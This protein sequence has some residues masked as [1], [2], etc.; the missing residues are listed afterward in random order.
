MNPFQKLALTLF[1]VALFAANAMAQCAGKQV[2][3]ELPSDWTKSEVYIK[4]DGMTTIPATTS[5]SWTIFTFPATSDFN[6]AGK[7]FG[8]SNNPAESGTNNWINR[9]QYNFVGQVGTRISCAA[10]TFNADGRVYIYPNPNNPSQTMVTQLPPNAYNFYFLPPDDPEWTVGIPLLVWFDGTLQKEKLDYDASRCGW[11]KKTWFN[12]TPPS[13]ITLIW[14][15]GGGAIGTPKGNPDDQLGILGFDEDPLDWDNGMPTP[16]SL[17]EQFQNITGGTGDLF[18]VPANGANGWYAT[19]PGGDGNCK[20]NF[21]AIIY[22]TDGSVNSSFLQGNTESGTGIRKNIPQ[23]VLAPDPVSGVMKMQFNTAKNGWTQQNFMDAFRPTTGKNVVRCYDMPFNRN[24]AGLWEFNSNKLCRLQNGNQDVVDLDGNCSNYGGF[25]GGFFPT[26]LQTAEGVTGLPGD[27][28][29]CSACRNTHTAESFVPLNATISEYCYDRG[30]T[31]TGTACGAEFVE[32]NFSDGEA[33]AIWN[34]G[35]T[36]PTIPN[37]NALYCFESSPAELTYEPGQQ[38][39]F[40]GDDDIW[41]Y[42][43]NQL[44]IDL[45]GSHLAAP[46]YVNLDDLVISPQAQA[47]TKDDDGAQKQFTPQGR[48][49][50]GEKYPINIFFC[51]RRLTMSNVRITTDMYFASKNTLGVSGNATGSG[52]AEI[53]LDKSGSVGTCKDVMSGGSGTI[54]GTQCGEAMG[55]IL[56]YYMQNRQGDTTGFSLDPLNPMCQKVGDNLVCY[57][58]IILENYYKNPVGSVSKIKVDY[59][60]TSGLMGTYRLYAKINDANKSSFPNEKPLFITTVRAEAVEQ[61]I[62]GKVVDDGG[63]FIFNLGPRHKKTVS[64][65]RVPVGFSTGDWDCTDD[66]RK[67]N[68]DCPFRVATWPA[69]ELGALGAQVS[70]PNVHTDPGGRESDLRWYKDSVGGAPVQKPSGGIVPANPAEAAAQG[71]SKMGL[72]IY[73]VTGE[74]EAANDQ[75]HTIGKEL[76]VEV[77]LPRLAFVDPGT[78]ARLNATQTQ[79]SEY[80]WSPG[81]TSFREADIMVGEPTIRA[82]AAYGAVGNDYKDFF[83]DRVCTSCNFDLRLN[84][85]ITIDGVRA[86]TASGAIMQPSPNP[87]KIEDGYADFNINGRMAVPGISNGH[88][89]LAFFTMGIQGSN[90]TREDILAEWNNLIFTA[91]PVPYPT[92]V[93]IYDVNGDGFGDSLHIIYNRKFPQVG[94]IRDSLPSMI[95]IAWD[96]DTVF[97]FG[98]GKKSSTDDSKWTTSGDPQAD[99][100]YWTN[101]SVGNFR[102]RMPNDST[103]AIYGDSLSKE[104]QTQV[105]TRNQITSEITN[106]ATYINPK[107]G[108][109]IPAD[110]GAK[111]GINDSIPAIVVKAIFEADKNTK[112]GSGR[113]STCKDQ[114]TITVSEPVKEIPGLG[115]V[116]PKA[117]FAYK[118]ISRGLSEFQRHDRDIHLAKSIRPNSTND[119]FFLNYERFRDG[120]D[121]TNTPMGGDSVKFVWAGLGEVVFTDMV[122]N[123]PN[124]R[125]QGRRFEGTNPFG[126]D[127][128]RIADLDP[129]KDI[130]KEAVNDVLGPTVSY[131]D[132]FKEDKQ[133]A[134]IPAED[135]WTADSIKIKF[136]G[137][138]GQFFSPD[139]ANT[140]SKM[141]NELGVKIDPSKITFH[142]KSF[143]HTNLGN[144]VVQSK[145]LVVS[146]TDKIFTAFGDANCMSNTGTPKG[147][148]LAWNLKDA[149]NRWVGAGAYVE[150]YDFYWQV[151]YDQG[152]GEKTRVIDNVEKRVEMLGVRRAK[153]K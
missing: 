74:Y 121:T 60:K 144:Y 150:V 26:E 23:N 18:F 113:T 7:S 119:V 19:D 58:G 122:G 90:A 91:P 126:V 102:M 42:I 48:L 136:P 97:R 73:W 145:E 17:M 88:D 5:G 114:V 35:A 142:A 16:F 83:P 115:N 92:S 30:R 11:F 59:S 33:P 128:I 101:G 40:S 52:G 118:L 61:Q 79:G 8:L 53:C 47:I 55:N 49:V 56:D 45:G 146:C 112:C 85:W 120:V 134:F 44:V 57:G 124:P 2:Y 96:P 14:L 133:V 152:G 138:V 139:V 75:I 69:S 132:L 93:S 131:E 140:V 98:P 129:E 10:S 103:I 100:T 34:W 111:F 43:S 13:G 28:T 94:S 153:K 25:M 64:G 12:A 84:A 95:E 81:V 135:S 21:A 32:G 4:S 116:L 54:Q 72:L 63:N 109:A 15:N 3:V 148:Y 149:K 38:F 82:V 89:S 51:D 31:G 104:I 36:R 71:D 125:E 117:P 41:V 106:W 105:K 65:K 37:K 99:Y 86:P 76:V 66:A 29:Q 68:D 137:S 67:G 141:E 39:F 143:Y 50:E 147:I 87:A 24:K 107:S 130:F 1:A 127:E 20:Y 77:V 70:I 80:P 46:G 22:D 9:N 108:S 27:Y 110:V 123:L 78:R 151:K 6:D 62:W